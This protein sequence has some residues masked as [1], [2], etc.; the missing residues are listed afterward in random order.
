M[1]PQ[2]AKIAYFSAEIGISSKLPTYSGGLGVLAG[3]HMKA[4]ADAGISLCGI[5]L[6]YK[7]GSAYV[8][9]I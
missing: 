3:D 2:C 7:L 8:S 1:K 6:L 5:T 9:H 4:A